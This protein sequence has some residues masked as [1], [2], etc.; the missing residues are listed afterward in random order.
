MRFE[1]GAAAGTEQGI[2]GAAYPFKL[3]NLS[4]AVLDALPVTASPD[5]FLHYFPLRADGLHSDGFQ[6]EQYHQAAVACGLGKEQ[7]F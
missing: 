7:R 2:S 6:K 1:S 4:E 3:E 5:C